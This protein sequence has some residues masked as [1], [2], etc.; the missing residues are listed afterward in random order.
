MFTGPRIQ[1]ELQ[2]QQVVDIEEVKIPEPV[3]GSEKVPFPVGLKQRWKP[4]GWSED[5]SYMYVV[6]DNAPM[7]CN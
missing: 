2:L 7:L 6:I 3:V 5:C 1:G 4:F